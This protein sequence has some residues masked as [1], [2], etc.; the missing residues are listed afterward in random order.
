MMPPMRALTLLVVL[1][2]AAPAA[3]Q[4]L[5]VYPPGY[6]TDGEL[7]AAQAEQRRRDVALE[8]RLNAQDAQ[9]R[10]DEGVS[11]LRDLSSRST[12]SFAPP[13]GPRAAPDAAAMATIPDARLSQSNARVR[14]A[15]KNRR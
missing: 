3:A 1:A 6:V 15:A 13:P 4:T 12:L 14:E 10:A 2:A 5:P 9:R 8:N 7:A 11:D